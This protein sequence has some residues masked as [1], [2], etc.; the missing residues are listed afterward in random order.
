MTQLVMAWQVIEWFYMK[1][2][3]KIDTKSIAKTVKVEKYIVEII[4]VESGIRRFKFWL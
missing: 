2:V 4:V 1:V 3:T